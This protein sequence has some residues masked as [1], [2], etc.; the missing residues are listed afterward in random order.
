MGKIIRLTG[1][2]TFLAMSQA[3]AG[4]AS[5]LALAEARAVASLFSESGIIRHFCVPC[6]DSAWRTERV[7]TVKE[8]R[9]RPDSDEWAVSVNGKS[10]DA[11][12][13]YVQW[14][15][16]WT[17]AAWAAGLSFPDIPSTLKSAL[18]KANIQ[19]A[20]SAFAFFTWS[21][22][23]SMEDSVRRAKSR[24]AATM[25]YTLKLF[26]F[27]DSLTAKLEVNGIDVAHRMGL[28]AL[29]RGDTVAMVLQRYLKQN[30]GRPYPPGATLFTLVRRMDGSVSTQWGALRPESQ[31]VT[32][33]GFRRHDLD[34][35]S[36]VE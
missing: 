4:H 9:A 26:D 31:A 13:I 28:R 15:G 34:P 1:M 11:A 32:A 23:Y 27:G 29:G 6:G 12:Y 33:A 30:F 20:D 22:T 10:V 2:M 8:L 18:T 36:L 24:H 3:L 25:D 14:K 19:P 16:R 5:V 7:R 35:N 21:G 17:N